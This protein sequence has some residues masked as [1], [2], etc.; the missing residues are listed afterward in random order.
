MKHIHFVIAALAATSPAAA[1]DW[2][3]H[4]Y[5]KAAHVALGGALSFGVAQH[6][7]KP[8]AGVVAATVAGAIKESTDRN[9]DTGDLAS[10]IVGGLAGA[11][12]SKHIVITPRGIAWRKG[13]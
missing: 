1:V 8:L 4:P 12:I 11:A 10:W 3:Q 13:F 5:D 9:F 2:H 6:F 7:D